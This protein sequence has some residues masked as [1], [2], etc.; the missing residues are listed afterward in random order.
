MAYT[1][2]HSGI[3]IGESDFEAT[4]DHPRQHFGG[5]RPTA[6]G[7]GVFP[8]LTGI[9]TAAHAIKAD[10]DAKGVLPDDLQPGEIEEI[11]DTTPAGQK[12]IDLGRTLSEVEMRDPDGRRIEFASIAFSDLLELQTLVRELEIES[13]AGLADVPNDAERYV[14]SATFLETA[15]DS[16]TA[17]RDRGGGSRRRAR[18]NDN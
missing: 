2:W 12:V 18:P 1:F 4:G 3:L 17:T 8:R 10:L 6:Y 9:L 7:L 5:F 13:S 15:P 11:L 16:A 14:V